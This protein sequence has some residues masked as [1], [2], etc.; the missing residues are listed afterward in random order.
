M[1]ILILQSAA[2]PRK[3]PAARSG[4]RLALPAPCS[5]FCK[6]Q[7]PQLQLSEPQGPGVLPAATWRRRMT[8][9]TVGRRTQASAATTIT[10]TM[11]CCMIFPFLKRRLG[12]RPLAHPPFPVHFVPRKGPAAA[13]AA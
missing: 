6:G 9:R 11:I 2:A 1:A 5:R 12:I 13:V 4:P 10:P 8:R 3:T 7:L